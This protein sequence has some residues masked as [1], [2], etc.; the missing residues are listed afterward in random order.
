MTIQN[1][2]IKAEYRGDIL[3]FYDVPEKPD[4]IELWIADKVTPL[5]KQVI[6]VHNNN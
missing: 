5:L 6:A 3:Y 4:M 1:N 2:V